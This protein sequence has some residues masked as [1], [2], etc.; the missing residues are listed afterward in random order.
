M[1]RSD[2]YD[3][4]LMRVHVK[5]K[6]Y[7]ENF[8]QKVTGYH[9]R[10]QWVRYKDFPRFTSDGVHQ[11]TSKRYRTWLARRQ[12]KPETPNL[13][14]KILLQRG[15]QLHKA[16]VTGD[17]GDGTYSIVYADGTKANV[18]LGPMLVSTNIRRRLALPEIETQQSSYSDPMV[19]IRGFACFYGIMLF[20]FAVFLC[21]RR[22]AKNRS[23][24]SSPSNANHDGDFEEAGPYFDQDDLA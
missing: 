1:A 15:T 7:T 9:K 8:Q 23:S 10:K 20:F 17:N 12:A 5:V 2:D 4:E 22:R 11:L 6:M 16:T 3:G 18:R 14:E 19:S 21:S 24:E 13:R